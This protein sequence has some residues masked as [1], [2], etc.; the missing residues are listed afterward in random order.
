[1]AYKKV[2]LADGVPVMF[3]GVYVLRWLPQWG[4]PTVGFVDISYNLDNALSDLYGVQLID[5][6]ASEADIAQKEIE[7]IFRKLVG[8]TE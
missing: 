7:A 6:T 8:E 1:M 2:E 4:S 3:L 5:N